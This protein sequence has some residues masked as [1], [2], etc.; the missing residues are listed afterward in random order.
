MTD[1]RMPREERLTDDDLVFILDAYDVWLQLPA[2]TLIQRYYA[3]LARADK[4]VAAAWHAQA[5]GAAPPPTHDV[6]IA[7]QKKCWPTERDGHATKCSILPESDLRADLYGPETDKD[8]KHH[9]HDIR[10]RYINSGS[11]MGTVGGMKRFFASSKDIVV[12]AAAAGTDYTS[13][14]GVLGAVLGAQEAWRK[15][16]REINARAA[17]GED[18]SG[19]AREWNATAE[20]G[21]GLDYRQDLFKPTVF[22]EDDGLYM[23]LGDEDNVRNASATA[24][25]DPPRIAGLPLDMRGIPSPLTYAGIL[26]ARGPDGDGDEDDPSWAEVPLYTDFWSEVVTVA[27][28][29]NAHRGG[30]KG[31]RLK[32]WWNHNWFFPYLRE[33]A[34]LSVQARPLRAITQV[35]AGGRK[36]E[37]WAPAADAKKPMPRIFDKESV[38]KGMK[39]ADWNS[40]CAGKNEKEWWDV[41]FQDGRGWSK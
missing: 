8:Y 14:Q 29:H 30:M 6:L 3:S 27:V 34:D 16:E 37:F 22:E 15:Q 21:L 26:D 19:A 11:I 38:E 36:L 40:L 32:E 7:S 35:N 28:H 18:V 12:A 41:V 5:P 24:G 39:Q 9:L 31:R 10:P 13:D 4:R 1:P 23:A 20:H 33:I 17:K 2:E 25:V